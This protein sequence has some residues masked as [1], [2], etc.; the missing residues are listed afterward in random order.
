[1]YQAP[2]SLGAVLAEIASGTTT[3]SAAFDAFRARA[4]ELEPHLG[5]FVAEDWRAA[6]AA[7]AAG[8]DLPLAGL[9]IGVKDIFDTADY[10]TENGSPLDSGRQPE[11]DAW[12]V[13]ALRA[14]GP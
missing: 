3:A 4:A 2:R 14:A 7:V 10:G 6:R 5:A 1:M 9:P 8:A 12:V 13:A 11:R